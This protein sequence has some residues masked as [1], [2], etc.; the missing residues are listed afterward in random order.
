[1]NEGSA[2]PVVAA[3]D[4]DGTLSDGGSVWQFLVAMAGRAR[5][6]FA[7]LCEVPKILV[8]AI[9]GGTANDRAKE[10]L[11]VRILGGMDAGDIARRAS[12]FGLVHFEKRVRP[13]VYQRLLDH[14][15]LGHKIVIVSASPELYLRGVAHKLGASELVA[16][17]LAIGT[18]GNLTGRYQGLNC[19][20]HEKWRRLD[21][22]LDKEA[23]E[24]S[25][26]PYVWAYGNS[27]GDR[28][29]LQNADR[30]VDVGKLGRLGKLRRFPRLKDLE[31]LD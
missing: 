17:H 13:E 15:R 12:T 28:E 23:V 21:E 14:Q 19:R 11:F 22:W 16:T 2:Q 8:A 10:A 26:R 9:L 29:M 30:G 27:A 1:V 4:F 31:P 24:S 25:V 3:F 20:G 6:T 5:A 18:D 7:G